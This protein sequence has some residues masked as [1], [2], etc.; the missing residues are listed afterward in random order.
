M[1]LPSSQGTAYYVRVSAY[2]MKGWGPPQ[3]SMPPSAI[4]SSKYHWECPHQL[5]AGLGEG[6][7]GV[8][9]TWEQRQHLE[10][11]AKQG[12]CAWGSGMLPP[13]DRSFAKYWFF[14]LKLFWLPGEG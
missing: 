8:W 3:A 4:P 13:A 2:N 5:W 1:W 14:N 7:V 11:R 10:S 12:D 9:W 6:W